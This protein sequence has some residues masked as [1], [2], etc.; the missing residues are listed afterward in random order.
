LQPQSSSNAALSRDSVSFRSATLDE[1]MRPEQAGPVSFRS[2]DRALIVASLDGRILQW[3]KFAEDIYGWSFNEVRGRDIL[4]TVFATPAKVEKQFNTKN[5]NWSGERTARRKDGTTVIIRVSLS[6]LRDHSGN[7]IGVLAQAKTASDDNGPARSG[8]NAPNAL[9]QVVNLQDEGSW[10]TDVMFDSM[11][12]GF[13]VCDVIRDENQALI[14][15]VIVA[16]NPALQAILGV[17]P[18]V[19]GTTLS[20]SGNNTKPWLDLCDEVLRSGK[21]KRF[22]F[23]NRRTERWHDIQIA[24]VNEDRLAQFF[25]DITTQKLA[26][27]RQKQMLAELNHRVKN[28]LTVVASVLRMQ[29]GHGHPEVRDQ[30]LKAVGRVHSIAEIYRSLSESHHNGIVNFGRYLKELCD[31]LAESLLDDTD[32]IRL[33]VEAVDA[34]IP[35]DT[36]VPLGMVVNELVTNAVKH[37]YPPPEQGEISVRFETDDA[38]CKLEI[39]DRGAG[40]PHDPAAKSPGLGMRLV[41][42]L[43]RQAGGDLETRHHP[44]VTYTIR[45]VPGQAALELIDS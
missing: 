35:I 29:A 40:L 7:P 16:I 5:L 2:I 15:Y 26:D 43:V 44:G 32:R 24:R 20:A 37:A 45:F 4:E 17:G 6:T 10:I 3:N 9:P 21:P 36:A 31:A 12:E 33:S 39:G 34:E 11:L 14:D 28:N 1:L 13:A 27:L 8:E 22:E 41:N 18:E 30:L 38:G 25:L 42:T 23:H 19:V